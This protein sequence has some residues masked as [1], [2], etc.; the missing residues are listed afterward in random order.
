M[1][2]ITEIVTFKLPDGT[3]RE[4]VI[5]NYEKSVSTWRENPDLVRKNYLYDAEKGIAGGVYLWKE[6][7]HAEKWHGAEFRQRVKAIYGAEPKSQFF[8]TPIVVDNLTGEI[9]KDLGDP[10]PA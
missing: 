8:E 2:M 10:V 7:A 4:E 3:T 1:Q 5:S 9:A 6:K